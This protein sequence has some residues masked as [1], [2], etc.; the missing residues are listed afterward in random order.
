MHLAVNYLDRFLSLTENVDRNSLQLIGISVLFIAAKLEE[1]Y[2]PK[3]KQFES[4]C[5]GACSAN[6]ILGVE[7][8][9][10]KI[11]KWDIVPSTLPFW[12]NLYL[13]NAARWFPREFAIGMDSNL[14]STLSSYS[15]FLRDQHGGHG[16][17]LGREGRT[18]SAGHHNSQTRGSNSQNNNLQNT[19][20]CVR[21]LNGVGLKSRNFPGPLFKPIKYLAAMSLLD[22]AIHDIESLAF[23]YSVM[24][25]SAFYLKCCH[26]LANCE[27]ILKMCTG[28]DL[29]QLTMC[30]DWISTFKDLPMMM[31]TPPSQL[32]SRV[33]PSDQPNIQLLN[34]S[35]LDYMVNCHII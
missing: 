34:R 10:M 24:A 15:S 21:S 12:M 29:A 19:S 13:Q 25:A 3:L 20:N 26:G 27:E 35:I 9:V 6:E 16:H 11:L 30:I 5:D 4:V 18:G 1:I 2:P 33:H 31:E 17:G 28:Y 14:T 23:S 22:A 32:Y 8:Q 7:L